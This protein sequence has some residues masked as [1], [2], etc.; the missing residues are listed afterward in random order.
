MKKILPIIIALS[1]VGLLQTGSYAQENTTHI[2]SH[3]CGTYD[4]SPQEP[5][6]RLNA[7]SLDISES[8]YILSVV[9]EDE[10]G[11]HELAFDTD[12][13]LIAAPIS[14]GELQISPDGQFF[15]RVLGTSF[16]CKFEGVA[17]VSPEAQL[18]LFK[19]TAKS[20]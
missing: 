14:D 9:F 11:Q 2:G 8:G 1:T 15:V 10:R 18:R 19:S 12:L 20:V 6:T 4:D 3:Q 7:A 16:Y 13:G 5:P 17:T